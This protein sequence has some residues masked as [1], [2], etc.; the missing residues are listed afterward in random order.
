PIPGQVWKKNRAE[1]Q[2][3]EIHEWAENRGRK[4]APRRK[5][6]LSAFSKK[7][8]KRFRDHCAEQ[9]PRNRLR[10]APR[11]GRVHPSK[12][13]LRRDPYQRQ[14]PRRSLPDDRCRDSGT[15]DPRA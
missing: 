4:K 10:T 5:L 2:E 11:D 6:A 14:S 15:T 13:R 7:L 1:C 9:N 12:E 8:R 3:R